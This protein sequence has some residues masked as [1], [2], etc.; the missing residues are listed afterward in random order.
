MLE[1]MGT[2]RVVTRWGVC[3]G[4]FGNRA[5]VG[6]HYLLHSHLVDFGYFTFELVLKCVAH[7]FIRLKCYKL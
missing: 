2:V 6:L 7:V 4:D 3:G 5:G 1:A